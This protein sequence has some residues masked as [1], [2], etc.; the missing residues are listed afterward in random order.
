MPLACSAR[1]Y[2][3][4]SGLGHCP[5]GQRLGH[6]IR[7]ITALERHGAPQTRQRI[8]QQADAQWPGYVF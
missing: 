7:P 5:T 8:D 4:R 2:R 6:G 1:P 3:T